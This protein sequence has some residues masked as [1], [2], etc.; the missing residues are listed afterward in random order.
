MSASRASPAGDDGADEEFTLRGGLG[1]S[2]LNGS[3][4]LHGIMP[5]RDGAVDRSLRQTDTLMKYYNILYVVLIE[6]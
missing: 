4:D 3:S 6:V 5:L 1:I 2:E